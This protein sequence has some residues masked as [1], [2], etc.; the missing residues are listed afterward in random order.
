VRK[1]L[2]SEQLGDPEVEELGYS[3][4]CD[5]D[6]AR[7]EVA[8]DDEIAVGKV[9]CQGDVSKELNTVVRR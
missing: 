8:M 5:K 2:G 9:D 7:L 4:A 1:V 6:V 3:V